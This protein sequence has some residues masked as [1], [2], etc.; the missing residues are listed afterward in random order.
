MSTPETQA[1]AEA[2][3][4]E[5][6]AFEAH[7]KHLELD[8]S[9]DE[10]QGR[11]V[12]RHDHIDC[13][14]EGWQARASKAQPK[15][16]EPSAVAGAADR[17]FYDAGYEAGKRAAQA[18]A[19]ATCL[20]DA[21]E[22]TYNGAC[23]YACGQAPAPVDGE[24][25]RLRQALKFY[26]DGDHFTR[27]QPEAWDTVSGEPSNFYEDEAATATV[28][29]GSV[30]K[31]ALDG[32]ELQDEHGLP[33]SAAFDALRELVA[34]KDLKQR[35]EALHF[36]G[37]LSEL[38]EGW[39]AEYDR[40]RAEYIR[41]QPAAWE[42][43]RD[44]LKS[45]SAV[46]APAVTHGWQPIKTAPKDGTHILVWTDASDTAYVVCWAD[47]AAGIRKYLT[48][49]SGAERGWHLAWDGELFDREHEPT[50]WMPL[51]DAPGSHVPVQG[52]EQ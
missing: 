6:A 42:V 12:Y 51:P 45:P 33:L 5:R 7:F 37:P 47:A 10:W 25:A 13:L 3:G 50:H 43:A 22:C 36:A 27:H 28:E 17:H 14:W 44:L 46:Q 11:I 15:G 48:A 41:R 52:S 16:V 49:E 4:D 9:Y 32:I 23:M 38:G 2:H 20:G 24:I 21:G 30:A 35:A 39:K 1:P 26:A 18:P 34:C 40:L 31:A 29:D 8:Y 19:P